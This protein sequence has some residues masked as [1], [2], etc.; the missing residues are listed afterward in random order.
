MAVIDKFF[1]FYAQ[2]Q[3]FGIAVDVDCAFDVV[4]GFAVACVKDH[5]SCVVFDAAIVAEAPEIEI[6]F[7]NATGTAAAAIT[8]GYAAVIFAG[9][10][11]VAADDN[12]VVL[13]IVA[14]AA[15]IIDFIFVV[16]IL[17]P[18]ATVIGGV[19]AFTFAALRGS[20]V[21]C[22]RHAALDSIADGES[23]HSSAMGSAA[24]FC[25]LG[26]AVDRCDKFG[27][28]EATS[29]VFLQQRIQITDACI[30]RVG[31]SFHN[32]QNIR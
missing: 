10:R 30:F 17:S 19:S 32:I 2:G 9:R 5:V 26:K 21:V 28:A 8:K 23:C 20:D 25:A 7:R 4:G 11:K 29:T 3:N 27:I 1:S 13:A 22:Q 15:Q 14:D 6:V 24:V 12:A 18:D 16:D 31:V